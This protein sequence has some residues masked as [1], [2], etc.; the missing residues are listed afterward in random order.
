MVLRN[1]LLV[2][3]IAASAVASTAAQ[4][5][6]LTGT[7][8]FGVETGNTGGVGFT[9]LPGPTPF[10]G[11]TANATFTYTGALNFNNPA[12][13]NSN[14]SGDLNS[15]FFTSGGGTIN[16]LS[17]SG[18]G[19][20]IPGNDHYGTL[21]GFLAGSGSAGS[22]A[23]GSLYTIDLGVLN[24]GTV[25]TI[26]HDDGASVFQGS[27]R[28]NSTVAGPTTV[29]TDVVTLGTTGDTILYYSRQ[30]GTPSILEVSAVPEPSTWAMMI[31]GFFG[32]GFMAYR[33]KQN[34]PS[35]RLA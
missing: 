33:R 9:T 24:A 4:A 35:L 23:Y 28:V 14:S 3:A 21:G 31:L 34:G 5:A 16:P 6:V 22:F 13:Q 19:N 32:V 25:L 18:S 7:F 17:Y 15:T 26:T 2:G 20:F 8:V 29:T 10:T 30:N 1:L 12:G 11:P 27:T